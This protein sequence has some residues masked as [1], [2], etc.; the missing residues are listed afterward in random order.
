MLR[1]PGCHRKRD[2]TG[3]AANRRATESPETED[4][5]TDGRL[6]RSK[7]GPAARSGAVP[8]SAPRARAKSSRTGIRRKASSGSGRATHR[9]TEL[10]GATRPRRTTRRRISG[11]RVI[12]QRVIG[13]R[14]GA[15][16]RIAARRSRHLKT[17][18]V[19]TVRRGRPPERRHLAARPRVTLLANAGHRQTGHRKT[20]RP[21]DS[22]RRS[23]LLKVDP[24]RV[25]PRRVAPRKAVRRR[26]APRT[27]TEALRNDPGAGRL[28]NRPPRRRRKTPST[29]TGRS[30]WPTTTPTTPSF[31][32]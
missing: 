1:E 30:T 6:A 2:Q 27:E 28:R 9:E 22:P 13:R 32:A 5:A 14:I 24:Q 31:G 12:G 7:A 21:T 17:V 15:R 19:R 10:P 26:A 11:R 4:P 8:V 18:R 20:G 29:R 23:D 16:P 25:A 3:R